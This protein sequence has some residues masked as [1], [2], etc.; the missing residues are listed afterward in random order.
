M[1]AFRE[2]EHVVAEVHRHWLPFVGQGIAYIL[3]AAFPFVLE[4][5]AGSLHGSIANAIDH[6]TS[7][8]L[9]LECAWILVLWMLF[10]VSW[11][12]HYLDVLIITNQRAIDIEQFGLFSRDIAEVPLEHIEDIKVERHGILSEWLDFGNLAMQTAAESKE[13]NLHNME[14]P[15]KIKD[16]ISKCAADIAHGH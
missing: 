1:I 12:N 11:T 6:Y 7:H 8:I 13:F 5:F 16:L 14:H 9:L 2:N 15:E 4:F 10:A 3:L